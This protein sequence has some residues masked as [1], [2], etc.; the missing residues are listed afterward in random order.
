MAGD[1][2]LVLT[3]DL[4]DGGRS[5]RQLDVRRRPIRPSRRVDL[6]RLP[7]VGA[8]LRWRHL[9]LRCSSCCSRCRPPWWRTA[10]WVRRSGPRNLATVTTSIHWRGLL[11]VGLLIAG[12]VFCTRCPMVLARDA[13]RRVFHARLRWPRRLAR[14]VAG[15]RAAGGACCSP[16]SSSTCGRCRRPP[17]GSSSATSARRWPWTCCLP[18]RCSASTS[19]R[20]AS[21]TSWRPRC[22]RPSCGCVSRDTCRTCRTADCIKGRRDAADPSVIRQRGCELGLFLPAKVGNLDCTLCLDCVHAC[23]HDNIA[24]AVRAPG[25]RA[26]RVRPP[27]GHRHAGATAGPGGAGGGVRRRRAGHRRSR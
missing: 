22:R 11:V 12:N 18:A 14:Q 21:S 1:W 24:L 6:L 13:G 2:V 25:R 4:P 26:A 9:R 7:V 17:R 19:A 20:S 10:C 23:P 5:T 16:T 15:H 3:G 8:V 27:L